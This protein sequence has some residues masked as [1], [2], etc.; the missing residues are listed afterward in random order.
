MINSFRTVLSF[1]VYSGRIFPKTIR[2]YPAGHFPLILFCCLTCTPRTLQGA[3]KGFLRWTEAAQAWPTLVV[4]AGLLPRCRGLRRR[5]LGY[6]PRRS[7]RNTRHRSP[8]RSRELGL[9]FTVRVFA[10]FEWLTDLT[11]HVY[12]TT[13]F[14]LQKNNLPVAIMAD[15]ILPA[16]PPMKFLLR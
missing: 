15:P 12:G 11:I 9:R 8:A 10:R 1:K 6:R 4:V 3:D 14:H 13:I 7:G 5:R 16:L 2:E